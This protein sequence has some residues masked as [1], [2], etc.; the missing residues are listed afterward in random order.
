QEGGSSSST[1]KADTSGGGASQGGPAPSSASHTASSGGDPGQ[2]NAP[3]DNSQT[4]NSSSGAKESDKAPSSTSQTGT[5]S[6]KP[7]HVDLAP[8]YVQSAHPTSGKPKGQN[9]TEGGFDDDPSK[10]ASFNSD[11]G[12]ENDPGRAAENKFQREAAEAGADAGGGPRQKAI[13]GDGQ[14]DLLEDDQG[15]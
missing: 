12:D 4:G 3:S 9:I 2:G 13:T 11:I 6:D 14:Y 15:L 10:N 7:Q 5:S 1:Y 8:S